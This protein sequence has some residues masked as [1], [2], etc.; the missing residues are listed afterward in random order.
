MR[1]ANIPNVNDLSVSYDAGFYDW[2]CILPSGAFTPVD[3]LEAPNLRILPEIEVL[4]QSPP[5]AI[6]PPSPV[7]VWTSALNYVLADGSG[8]VTF[9]L[10]PPAGVYGLVLRLTPVWERTV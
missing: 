4:Q 6:A 2:T 8:F 7:L 10:Q 1:R 9:T 3:A 5:L